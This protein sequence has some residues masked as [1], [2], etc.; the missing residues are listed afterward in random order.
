VNKEKMGLIG[1]PFQHA[2]TSTLWKKSEYLEWDFGSTKNEKTFYVDA[3]ILNGLSDDAN[4]K[5]Y[6]WLLESRKIVPGLVDFIIQNLDIVLKTYEAIFTHNKRLLSLDDKFKWTPAYGLYIQEPKIYEK[7]KILSMITSNKTMT[8]NHEFRNHLAE[9]WKNRLDLYGRGYNEIE[10][11]EE[12]LADYMFSIAIENDCYGTYFT[13]KIMDCFAVGTIPVYLG[14]PDI[15]EHFNI[16][17]IVVLDKDFDI[18]N[19]T[20]ALYRDKLDI[21][22]E[23]FERVLQYNVLEDWIYKRYFG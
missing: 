18:N 22:K 16:D 13:E 4:T 20:K 7:T 23:N 11:K 15:G 6:A 3:Q 8:K 21:V 10:S 5:K 9:I 2:H 1:G 17:G 14:A 12:G 19:L